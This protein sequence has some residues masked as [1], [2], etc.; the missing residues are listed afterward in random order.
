[1]DRSPMSL[2]TY[3]LWK[4]RL[5]EH[6]AESIHYLGVISSSGGL[7]T[8]ILLFILSLVYYEDLLAAIPEKT[9]LAL[10][11][12]LILAGVITRV[13][14]RTLLKEADLLFLPVIEG[15]MERYWQ[16]AQRYNLAIQLL[17]VASFLILLMPIYTHKT[18]DSQQSLILYF[19]IPLLLKGWNLH[20]HWHALQVQ[21]RKLVLRHTCIRYIM[22]FIILY[23]FFSGGILFGH[24]VWMGMVPF[25]ALAFIWVYLQEKGWQE[26]ES[27]NWL[28]LVEMEKDLRNRFYTFVNAFFTDVPHLESKVKKRAWLSLLTD[29]LPFRRE[30]S[31]RYLYLK[32]F[33]RANEYLGLY[34]RLTLI[35][36]LLVSFL[37][38]IYSRG[39]GY[40]LF[41]WI[42]STQLKA[43]WA[44]HERQFWVKLY[45]LS[46]AL[47]VK[48]FVWLSSLLLAIQAILM[49]VPLFLVSDALLETLVLLIMGLGFSYFYPRFIIN[50]YCRDD[51]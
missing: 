33:I 45:P 20:S 12:S 1:M 18:P 25:L 22:T 27:L 10:L 46:K 32:T 48:A 26:T 13:R 16:R 21:D 19:L 5:R 37:P 6:L 49:L 50:T 30:M 2:D 42:V 4:K 24:P 31:Y 36:L 15:K 39:T 28:V 44:H 29:W 34:F 41:L 35:G 23:L 51:G 14:F 3:Q 40:L 47:Q 43:L 17:H 11:F 8:L 9:P 7:L 38:D